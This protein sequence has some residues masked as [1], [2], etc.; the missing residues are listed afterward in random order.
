MIIPNESKWVTLW[1]KA[2]YEF[3]MEKGE[4]I[5]R[6]KSDQDLKQTNQQIK[7]TPVLAPE[8]KEAQ[9]WWKVQWM[10]CTVHSD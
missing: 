5:Q 9:L 1:A 2:N 7:D 3:F 10:L 8:L 6:E 4:R